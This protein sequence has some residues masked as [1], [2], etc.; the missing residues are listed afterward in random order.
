MIVTRVARAFA[1]RR[2]TGKKKPAEGRGFNS[3]EHPR[4]CGR[5]RGADGVAAVRAIWTDYGVTASKPLTKI[6]STGVAAQLCT[7]T[8]STYQPCGVKPSELSVVVRK[9]KRTLWPA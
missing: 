3:G 1:M 5:M 2:R 6:R 9:R 4:L 8:W 7:F